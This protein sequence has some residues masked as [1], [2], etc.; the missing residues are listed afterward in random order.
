MG[1]KDITVEGLVERLGRL[2]EELRGLKAQAGQAPAPSHGLDPALEQYLEKHLSPAP[3]RDG[4][5]GVV[6]Y[7]GLLKLPDEAGGATSAWVITVTEDRLF[8]LPLEQAERRLAPFARKERLAI[9]RALFGQ[10]KSVAEL[11]ES[12]GLTQGQIYHHLKELCQAEYVSSP[13]RNS[14]TLDPKGQ[15]ALMTLLA[16]ALQMSAPQPSSEVREEPPPS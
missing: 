3:G 4:V 10:T 16:V 1:S 12:T 14:Y 8:D 9:L 6:L 7:A 2:E 15:I 11:A 13:S 5:R